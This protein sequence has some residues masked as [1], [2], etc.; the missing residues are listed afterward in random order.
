MAEIETDVFP[1]DEAKRI[2]DFLLKAFEDEVKENIKPDWA[3]LYTAAQQFISTYNSLERMIHNS[4]SAQRKNLMKMEIMSQN[5]IA[6]KEAS[7]TQYL[8]R[9]QFIAAFAF[10][11]VLTKFRDQSQRLALIVHYDEKNQ[12]VHQ[13]KI[14]L[15]VLA[16]YSRGKKGAFNIGKQA[17]FRLQEEYKDL[18][19][20]SVQDDHQKAAEIAFLG[21][22]NRLNNFFKTMSKSDK[23]ASA[24]LMWNLSKNNP[25]TW[26][27]ARVNGFG[28]VKE[29]YI[30]AFY[31][32]HGDSRQDKLVSEENVGSPPWYNDALIESFFY[33]IQRVT[34]L[35]AI[36]EEDVVTDTAQY[37]VKS[38]GARL[39]SIQQY[40]NVAVEI[41]LRGPSGDS[42]FNLENTIK[43]L[44]PADAER[45]AIIAEG[46]QLIRENLNNNILN[47]LKEETY[48]KLEYYL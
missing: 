46:N 29:A 21:T 3:E 24:L 43:E 4:R 18:N 11:K 41:Y 25:K 42:D 10:D 16:L 23:R 38:T 45:N 8:R 28:D 37:A 27:V 1:Q 9:A 17:F 39:P 36:V 26:V 40:L 6:Q 15:E 7:E 35:A 12:E 2:N 19:K 30:A 14:P 32:K 33:Y 20:K 5:Y 48:F 31:A 47:W 13:L 44:Y 22:T 34:N